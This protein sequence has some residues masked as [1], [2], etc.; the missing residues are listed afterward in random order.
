M[1]KI[2]I[3]FDDSYTSSSKFTAGVGKIYTWT[4]FNVVHPTKCY[5]PVF[6]E[7]IP[8]TPSVWC[9]M[10]KTNIYFYTIRTLKDNTPVG[11]GK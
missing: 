4:G 3:Y 2:N 5:L 11:D 6:D 1:I 7:V 8:K 9:I 10:I